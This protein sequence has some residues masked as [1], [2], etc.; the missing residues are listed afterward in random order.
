MTTTRDDAREEEAE[1]NERATRA[2]SRDF[3]ERLTRSVAD[4]R[5][6]RLSVDAQG[7]VDRSHGDHGD[8]YRARGGRERRFGSGD[9]FL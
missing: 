7:E 3:E 2:G 6:N 8:E 1:R 9:I 4:V 5:A